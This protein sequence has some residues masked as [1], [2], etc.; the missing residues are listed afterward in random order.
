MSKAN[1]LLMVIVAFCGGFALS[2]YLMLGVQQTSSA[3]TEVRLMPDTLA[4]SSRSPIHVLNN[5]E[6]SAGN[7]LALNTVSER[8]VGNSSSDSSTASI[9]L[10]QIQQLVIDGYYKEAVRLARLYL[11]E[12]TASVP[13]WYLLAQ[14]YQRLQQPQ[15]AMDAFFR[16]LDVEIDSKKA[17]RV[18]RELKTYLLE[19]SKKS[20]LFNDDIPWLIAQYD[21]LLKRKPND[22]EIHL[23]LADIFL[24][25]NDSYQAQYH[26][27]MAINDAGT[28]KRAEH[29]LSKLNKSDVN[30][31]ILIPLVHIGNQFIL[32]ASIEGNSVRLLVDTG[33]SISG[34]T[35]RF[36]R[37]YPALIRE[38]KP[39]N[40]HTAG[41]V[42]ETFLFKVENIM[43]ESLVLNQQILVE[44]PMAD[45]QDFDGLLG[46]DILGRFDFKIDQDA[47]VLRL[48]PRL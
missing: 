48:K 23:S 22:G 44:L 27:L 21:E 31:E 47:N 42:F 39:I 15:A 29:L 1:V 4:L 7:N 33:A 45:A 41:G 16:Y 43:F 28:K 30:D 11:N 26:I 10:A 40:L 14:A 18:I 2:Q 6:N 5:I 38:K 9:T 46:V 13:A 32:T 35:R 19:L 3:A 37:Q 12:N 17:E 36:T 20:A 24:Q 8:F 34:V 25:A